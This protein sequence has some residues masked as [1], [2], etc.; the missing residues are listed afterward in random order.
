ME[1]F[2]AKCIAD[3]TIQDINVGKVYCIEY[4][5]DYKVIYNETKKTYEPVVGNK[6]WFYGH[7]KPLRCVC[8]GDRDFCK[9]YEKGRE[10]ACYGFMKERY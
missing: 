4:D 9:V 8:C 5:L 1:K 10:Y 2:L 6:E 3:T 7:F